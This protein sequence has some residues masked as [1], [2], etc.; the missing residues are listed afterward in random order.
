MM[1]SAKT[2]TLHIRM[3]DAVFKPEQNNLVDILKSGDVV[4]VS[5]LESKKQ[6]TTPLYIRQHLIDKQKELYSFLEDEFKS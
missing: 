6:W 1:L 4:L 5:R 2:H 3:V